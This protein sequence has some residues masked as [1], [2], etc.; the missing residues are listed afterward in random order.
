MNEKHRKRFEAMLAQGEDRQTLNLLMAYKGSYRFDEELF[1]RIAECFERMD[2]LSKAGLYRMLTSASDATALASIEAAKKAYRWKFPGCL[3][4]HVP[5]DR[6]PRHTLDK[7]CGHLKE[8]G[9][10]DPMRVL[11]K[12]NRFARKKRKLS[13]KQDLIALWGC[14]LIVTAVGMLFVWGISFIASKLFGYQMVL[15]SDN[16]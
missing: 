15:G 5:I 11:R 2:R 16:P 6:L 1:Q 10:D 9:I 14:G 12:S 4:I 8:L 13:R 7:I 3:P